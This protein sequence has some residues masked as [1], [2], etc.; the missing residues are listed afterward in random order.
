M[1]KKGFKG[2]GMEGFIARSYDKNTREY[3]KNEINDWAIKLSEKIANGSSFLEIAPGPGYLW[4]T[5]AK[6]GK[7]KVTCLEI[8]N[9]FIEIINENAKKEKVKINV[10]HGNASR[11]QVDDNSFDYIFCSAA[12]KNFSEPLK[13]LQEMERVLKPGGKAEIV[14]MRKDISNKA[15]NDYVDNSMKG[16]GFNAFFL[17]IIFKYFL[18]NRAYSKEQFMDFISKTK[19]KKYNIEDFPLGYDVILEK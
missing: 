3:R 2:I 7:F 4:I 9:T 17:K 13:A 19:F 11:M 16:K 18:K 10:V 15:I 1:S 12:F 5:L 8:S 14:D 6:T